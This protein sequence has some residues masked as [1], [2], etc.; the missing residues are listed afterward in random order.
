MLGWQTETQKSLLLDLL[1][2]F[3]EFVQRTQC[4]PNFVVDFSWE[5]VTRPSRYWNCIVILLFGHLLHTIANLTI[6]LVAWRLNY[7]QVDNQLSLILRQTRLILDLM[8][9]YELGLGN[10]VSRSALWNCNLLMGLTRDDKWVAQLSF[11]AKQL[12]LISICNSTIVYN[13]R[14]I[15]LVS[16]VFRERFDWQRQFFRTQV[17][18]D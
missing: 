4:H 15:G 14:R 17:L 10:I 1:C 2:E 7:W 3:D 13:I 11:A 6:C 5:K 9:W 8:Q 12:V 16:R 18:W